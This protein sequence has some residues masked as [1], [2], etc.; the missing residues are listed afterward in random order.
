M[1]RVYIFHFRGGS[2]ETLLGHSAQEA[3]NNS[4]SSTYDL[5]YY[6]APDDEDYS[7]NPYT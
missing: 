4:G 5:D 1:P 3:F 2:T 6:E 7:W